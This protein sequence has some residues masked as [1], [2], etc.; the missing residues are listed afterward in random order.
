MDE[1]I[2]C[3]SYF[4]KAAEKKKAETLAQYID[5]GSIYWHAKN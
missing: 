3:E 5:I 1:F 4:N 2:V